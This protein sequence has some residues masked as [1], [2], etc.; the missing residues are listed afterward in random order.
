[1]EEIEAAAVLRSSLKELEEIHDLLDSFQQTR[2]KQHL[3]QVSFKMKQMLPQI[4][5]MSL[6]PEYKT[7]AN[8]PLL[9]QLSNGMKEAVTRTKQLG[10]YASSSSLSTSPP[11]SAPSPSSADDLSSP[12]ARKDSFNSLPQQLE[13]ESS[14]NSNTDIPLSTSPSSGGGPQ[15]PHPPLSGYLN[16]LGEKGLIKSWKKRWFTQKENRL[17]YFSSETDKTPNGFIDLAKALDFVDLNDDVAKGSKEEAF[18]IVCSDRTFHLQGLAPGSA[19]RWVREL[20]AWRLWYDWKASHPSTAR[21]APAPVIRKG[22]AYY[23]S[24]SAASSPSS[25]LAT[26]PTSTP[27]HRSSPLQQLQK[28]PSSSPQQEQGQQEKQR[29]ESSTSLPA[30][31]FSVPV[32]QQTSSTTTDKKEEQEKEMTEEKTTNKEREYITDAEEEKAKG[33]EERQITIETEQRTNEEKPG[34]ST[35]ASLPEQQNGLKDSDKEQ[36]KEEREA[37]RKS[38]LLVVPKEKEQ[39]FAKQNEIANN[40]NEVNE[41]AHKV[42]ALEALLRRKEEDY[43]FLKE[44]HRRTKEELTIKE[45]QVEGLLDD[46]NLARREVQAKHEQITSLRNSSSNNKEDDQ[47]NDVYGAMSR[48]KKSNGN[49]SSSS[50]AQQ[51]QR[52]EEEISQLQQASHAHQTQNA[53]L[54]SELKRLEREHEIVVTTKTQTL[55]K[56]QKE[57]DEV[58]KQY[59]QLRQHALLGTSPQP[60]SSASSSSVLEEK[61]EMIEELKRKYFFT[62]VLGI[63]LNLSYLGSSPKEVCASSL[64]EE[65]QSMHYDKWNAW[66]YQKLAS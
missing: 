60:S 13:A 39:T 1:M 48:E 44:K 40:S 53:F 20:K 64:Y 10:A 36:Q 12:S 29:K 3:A 59:Q 41:L 17:Y 2:D 14:K 66:V 7:P 47:Q 4:K 9:V 22:S 63:K 50:A 16:K 28:V 8:A 58:R 45:E 38:S 62:L 31:S 57:L 35:S 26:S 42:A 55:A 61:E 49:L 5:E 30:P 65:A 52:L 54:S 56:V 46:L 51:I 32:T 43:D 25:G 18:D 23:A 27:T 6:K 21:S 19:R 33:E 24:T 34:N 11:A 37:R 15:K